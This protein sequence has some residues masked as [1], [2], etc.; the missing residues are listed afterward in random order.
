[1]K[2]RF[3][4][5][6]YSLIFVSFIEKNERCR[7]YDTSPWSTCTYKILLTM[8]IIW[9]SL[10]LSIIKLLYV[11]W[12]ISIEI[13][14]S[15]I[16]RW[17]KNRGILIPRNSKFSKNPT[18]PT[19]KAWASNTTQFWKSLKIPPKKPHECGIFQK[20]LNPTFSKSHAWAN[21]YSVA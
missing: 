20:C 7:I 4:P 13:F 16:P 6:V 10:I 14:L 18:D 11:I 1:M 3:T 19:K 17:L 21:V 8:K 9:V 5:C 15:E 2:W 12:F